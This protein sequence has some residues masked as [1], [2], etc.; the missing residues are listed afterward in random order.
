VTNSTYLDIF[1]SFSPDGNTLAYSSNENGSLEIYLKQLTPGGSVVQ[2]TNDGGRNTEPA[3]SPDGSTIA[4]YSNVRGGIWL[5]PALGG[6]ARQLTTFGSSPAWS[7]DGTQI[8]FE[9]EGGINLAATNNVSIS[10]ATLWIV[11]V[12]GGTPRQLTQVDKPAGAHNSPAWSP[13]GRTIAFITAGFKVPG[14]WTVS[15]ADGSLRRISDGTFFNP[16]YA[17]DGR[18][19][20]VS[21]EFALWKGSVD[22]PESAH[23]EHVKIADLVPETPRYLALSRDGR[24]IAFSRIGSSS[25]IYS[26]P[27]AGDHPAG[28]PVALTHD[29]RL[30]KTSPSLSFDGQRVLFE[31]G[32]VDRNGGVWVMDADG[33][34][35]RLVPVGCDIP[36]W[37][38]GN[39]DFLC[40][41]Y[42][43]EDAPECKEGD[44]KCW[45]P[46]ILKVHLATGTRETLLHLGQDAAFFNYS[47]DGKQ[48]AFMSVKTVRRTRG[49]RR[50][51]AALLGRSR[52][53]ARRWA[54]RLGRLTAKCWRWNRSAA[55]A[56]TFGW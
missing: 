28:P 44:E 50:S 48:V 22:G 30:R 52:S 16:V 1:P 46:D 33:K 36:R 55:T 15:V 45:L 43:K 51:T 25:N 29:T 26:L 31:V 9:S 41:E 7:P 17:P 5:M 11:P 6:V 54:G 56:A 38:P 10:G 20:Y 12:N 37:L 40:T 23:P 39:E 4:Y 32:S 21:T 13:D 27:M 47:R 53:I 14:L 18:H 8:A 49:R 19:I 42:V 2:L 3:W 34:N 24:K 35:S